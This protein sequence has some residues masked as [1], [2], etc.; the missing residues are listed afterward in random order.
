MRYG[1]FQSEGCKDSIAPSA[2]RR[3]ENVFFKDPAGVYALASAW[4]IGRTPKRSFNPTPGGI[5][6]TQPMQR[7]QDGNINRKDDYFRWASVLAQL[8]LIQ[9]GQF[10]AKPVIGIDGFNRTVFDQAFQL[11]L[12]RIGKLPIGFVYGHT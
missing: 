1:E 6:L 5:R 11:A 3:K 4:R 10:I 12:K 8:Y 2:Q 7:R 9:L